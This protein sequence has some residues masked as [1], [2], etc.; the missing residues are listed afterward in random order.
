MKQKLEQSIQTLD[1]RCITAFLPGETGPIV[2]LRSPGGLDIGEGKSDSAIIAS[3][4]MKKME[5][6]KKKEEG[7]F[8]TKSMRTLLHFTYLISVL[9][10]LSFLSQFHSI[11]LH[12][13]YR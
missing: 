8:T 10:C 9:Q 3:Q 12:N 5:E 1:D 13:V 2:S 4:M 6:R 7:G 11:V